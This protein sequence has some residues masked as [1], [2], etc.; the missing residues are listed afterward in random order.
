MKHAYNFT[1]RH[2]FAEFLFPKKSNN[3]PK[4]R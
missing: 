2:A 3:D 1:A 4:A